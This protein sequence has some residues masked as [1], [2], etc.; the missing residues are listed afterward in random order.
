MDKQVNLTDIII[1]VHT[2]DLIALAMYSITSLTY[3]MHVLYY[4]FRASVQF[5]L[6]LLVRI[7]YRQGT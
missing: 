7:V 5:G 3:I 4:D 1:I 2:E 6:Q